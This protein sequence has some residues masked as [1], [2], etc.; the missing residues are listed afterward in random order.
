MQESNIPELQESNVFVCAFKL[1][2]NF[3]CVLRPVVVD[4]IQ[5]LIGNLYTNG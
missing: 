2:L 5:K 3:P 1:Y 4:L